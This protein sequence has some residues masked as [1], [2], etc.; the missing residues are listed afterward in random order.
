MI[1]LQEQEEAEIKATRHKHPYRK[2]RYPRIVIKRDL[3]DNVMCNH[4]MQE[5]DLL[6]ELIFPV[7]SSFLF[8]TNAVVPFDD[9]LV[10]NRQTYRQVP[11]SSVQAELAQIHPSI[12]YRQRI[13]LVDDE[14]YNLM[15]LTIILA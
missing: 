7:K 8:P 10:A 14:S 3:I 12:I 13:L 11:D 1:A 2:V 4:T 6:Q 9:T 5:E 15:A